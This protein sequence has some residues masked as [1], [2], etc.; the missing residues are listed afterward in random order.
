MNYQLLS[1][2]AYLI[3]REH[4]RPRLRVGT[5]RALVKLLTIFYIRERPKALHRGNAEAAKAAVI[6]AE[7]ERA[8]AHNPPAIPAARPHCQL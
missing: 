8:K 3:K 2:A 4:A 5:G 6:Y 7:G 1:L